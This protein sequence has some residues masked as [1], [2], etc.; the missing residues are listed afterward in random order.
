MGRY[1]DWSAVTNRYND[2][3]KIAGASEIGS[4]WLLAAENEVDG[5]LGALYTVPFTPCPPLVQ[6]LCTD[7]T[8]YKMTMR[9]DTSKP[10]KTYIDERIKA[11]LDG[12]MTLVNSG[13]GALGTLS[14]GGGYYSNEG[15]HSSF[16][17]DSVDNWRVSSNWMETA[18]SD[19]GDPLL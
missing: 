19:R 13:G 9:Q 18:Q 8:Y 11:I 14:G 3:A 10:I 2:A 16:G 1:I 5:W 7:L 17:P 12:R 6:D 15:D 4:A